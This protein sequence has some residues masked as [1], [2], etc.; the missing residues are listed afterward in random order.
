MK[1]SLALGAALFILIMTLVGLLA[2]CSSGNTAE[3]GA[4]H[5]W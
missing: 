3:R 2:G 1:K 5:L 4:Q